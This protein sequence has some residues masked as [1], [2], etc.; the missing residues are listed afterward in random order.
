[1][2]DRI[3]T[4]LKSQK[5]SLWGQA[6]SI[7]SDK[8]REITADWI[9]GFLNDLQLNTSTPEENSRPSWDAYYLGIA[10]A[11][12]ARGDCRRAK[13]GAVLVK[14]HRIAATGYNGTPPGN[15]GSC[16]AGDCPRALLSYEQLSEGSSYDTGAGACISTHAELNCLLRASWEDMQEATLYIT[17]KPCGGCQK[18]ID[19]SGVTRIVWKQQ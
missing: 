1:M 17:G 6:F 15:E 10:K 9:L 12:S 7:H 3:K 4:Y 8:D 18:V 5:S 13:H 2:K 14:G 19:S 16:L 11:V